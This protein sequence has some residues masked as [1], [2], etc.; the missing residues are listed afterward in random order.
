MPREK[1][2]I[3]VHDTKLLSEQWV[4]EDILDGMKKSVSECDVTQMLVFCEAFGRKHGILMEKINKSVGFS[5]EEKNQMR[6]DM[7][8][9]HNEAFGVMHGKRGF[10]NA[11]SCRRR[12]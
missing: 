10:A 2:D 6:E 9:M 5:T 4:L 11:C 8:N 12:R 3:W 7:I 1:S